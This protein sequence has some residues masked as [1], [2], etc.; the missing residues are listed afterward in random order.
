M[1][2]VFSHLMNSWTLE[3]KIP[4]DCL[5]SNILKYS[6]QNKFFFFLEEEWRN[7]QNK[8]GQSQNLLQLTSLSLGI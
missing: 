4:L 3:T 7:F 6:I 2:F 5:L 1:E 8:L